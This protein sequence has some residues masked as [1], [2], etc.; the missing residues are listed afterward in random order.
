MIKKLLAILD[1]W[2][3][4]REFVRRQI[5]LGK[6]EREERERQLRETDEKMMRIATIA[7]EAMADKLL[8]GLD[9]PRTKTK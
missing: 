7:A 8:K 1:K 4:N 9:A 6:L 3:M 5:A 2:L